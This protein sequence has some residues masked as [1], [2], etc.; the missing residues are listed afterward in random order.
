MKKKVW[1]GFI[2]L[3]GL[4]SPLYSQSKKDLWVDSIFNTLDVTGKI[5]QILMIPV[6]AH[7]EHQEID[8]INLLAKKYKIGGVVFTH[9]GPVAQANI[10]NALQQQ[11]G[12]PLLLGMNAEEGLGAVLD[13]CIRFPS[14]IMLGSIRDDSLLY[15][16]GA[17]VGR[18]LTALG[19]QL[20]FAPTADLSTSLDPETQLYFSYG[21]N[22]NN[23]A[24]KVVALLN[25]LNASGILSVAMH[26][27]SQEMRVE[28]FQKGVPVVTTQDDLHQFYALQRLFENGCVGLVTA[29]QQD[30]ITS[31]QKKIFTS[32][33]RIISQAVPALYSGD[34][35]K[36][37]LHFDGL[38]FSF[39][40]NVRELNKKLGS[41]DAE[42]FAFKAGND[43][44]LFPQNF[45]TA[46]RKIRRAVRKNTQL[47]RQLDESVRKILSAKFDAGLSHRK[48]INRENLLDKINTPTAT[49]L[50]SILYEKSVTVVKDDSSLLPIKQLD[51]ISFASLSV[52]GQ[53]ENTLT[54]YLSKYAPFTHYQLNIADTAQLLSDLQKHQ[55]VVAC[56]FP[57]T[58]E[59]DSV[60]SF[61]LQKINKHASVIVVNLG[62]PS[63]L[64]LV[65]QLPVIIQAYSDDDPV[66]RVL[67]QLL[68]GAKKIEGVLPVSIHATL[69]QGLGIQTSSLSRVG[70]ATP[71]TEGVDS[72][73]L[74]HIA[75]IANEAITQKA[76]PGCQILV[77]RHGKIIYE[78]SFGS[79]TYENKVPVNEA[80]I[81]D[82]ASVSKVVGTLQAVMFLQERGLIDIHKKASVYLPELLSTNK[83]D[84]I[85]QDILTH[86]A[87][88]VP[89]LLMWPQTAKGDTLLP[90]YYSHTR[91][92]SYPLQV[93][94][95]IFASH[96]I[97]DSIWSWVLKSEMLPKPA[98]TPYSTRYSDLGFM[99]L[100]RMVEHLI[101]Q[102]MEDF[103]S[104]NLYEP[105]GSAT[106]GYLPLNRFLPSQIAPTE[107]DT[108][109]RKSI[110]VGTVHDER[111]AM[112]GGVAGHAGLFGTASDLTKIGQMLLQ[113]GK[114]GGLLFYKPE[115]VDL[116]TQKQFEN[117]TRGLGWA[118]ATDP[119]SPSSRFISPQ[120]YGHTG[121]TG[122]CMWVDPEF[123]LVYIFLS[124]SR[125]PYRSGKLNTTNIRSR[126]QDIIYQSIFNYCQYNGNHPDEKLMQYL[127]KAN[128]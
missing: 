43:V 92:E 44:L 105:I 100:H 40:P 75:T 108:I 113:K 116:F 104:Q 22:K 41:G 11:A 74:N 32:K 127:V 79:Q 118:K 65:D 96:T 50:Q 45:S 109:F 80:T 61:F 62:A 26:Y 39:I 72:K 13:S 56:L 86:Q 19:V 126:I 73:T 89:F 88:L 17:E 31:D 106:M 87:G 49:A 28:G 128:N 97:Q 38:L 68:F 36:R 21:E 23:V 70:Y 9:G 64:V 124:N 37:Q 71:E 77:V 101:N 93:A 46:V 18:Q 34:Y 55:V 52:G 122:T 16:L 59:V 24:N 115:T 10:T 33:Q 94:P 85:I 121:F 90:H 123:D 20:N 15:F 30:L 53:K 3:Y 47:Q 12:V 112:L 95:E 1:I 8:R 69:K 84:I 117:S 35:L 29:N 120:A 66:Q 57:H 110:V 81:Y 42:L 60:L 63:K 82:L 7:A 102:P 125:F 5:G 14:P 76:A 103:L 99:I 4:I 25:G 83:K 67:P 91:T 107:L 6:N 48:V 111:A 119:N 27:P 51:N 2:V 78:K 114:Y 54:S 58:A 98:R